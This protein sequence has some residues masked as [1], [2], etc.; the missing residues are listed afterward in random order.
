M[1]EIIHAPPDSVAWLPCSLHLGQPQSCKAHA[2]WDIKRICKNS[3][4]RQETHLEIPTQT[5][6]NFWSQSTPSRYVI[7][8]EPQSPG[9]SRIV[10]IFFGFGV[11]EALRHW[12]HP[13]CRGRSWTPRYR[14][15]VWPLLPKPVGLELS[16]GKCDDHE[17]NQHLVPK[18]TRGQCTCINVYKLWFR[19]HSLGHDALQLQQCNVHPGSFWFPWK[20]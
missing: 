6:T 3:V 9:P 14:V 18:Q 15:V 20:T 8:M 10:P 19:M 17:T 4:L 5:W 1:K 12:H 7:L 13:L 16:G 2:T 11:L